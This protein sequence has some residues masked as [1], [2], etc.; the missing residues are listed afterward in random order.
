MCE[1]ATLEEYLLHLHDQIDERG[2]T[3]IG[4]ERRRSWNYTIGLA[5]VAHPE[6]VMAGVNLTEAAVIVNHLARGVL[7]GESLEGVDRVDAHGD[8]FRLVPVHERH[9]ENG[10][11]MNM[12]R[13]YYGSLGPPPPPLT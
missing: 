8:T 1:G 9:L 10:R 3:Q 6:L 13:N 2:F 12:W 4:V 5:G 11:L 7:R